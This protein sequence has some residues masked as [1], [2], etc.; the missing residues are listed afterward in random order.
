[1]TYQEA[2]SIAERA[3]VPYL[4]DDD[5]IMEAYNELMDVPM[6]RQDTA[7]LRN[8]ERRWEYQRREVIASHWRPF[9]RS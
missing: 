6:A 4:F 3:C 5:T 1:M 8:I 7:A 9:V 2:V